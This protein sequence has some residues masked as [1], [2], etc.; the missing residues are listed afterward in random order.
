[1]RTRST[2]PSPASIPQAADGLGYAGFNVHYALNLPIYKDD[3]LA[4]LGAS[5]FRALG[6]G[7]LLR[8]IRARACDRHGARVGRGVPALRRVLDREARGPMPMR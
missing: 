1:M 2:T 8:P 7:Q 4:F 3:V 6:K 5:Y